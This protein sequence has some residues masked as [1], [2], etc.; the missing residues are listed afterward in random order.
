[1]ITT[2]AVLRFNEQ[3]EAYLDSVHPGIEIEDVLDNTG[4]K[5]HVADNVGQTREPN[6]EELKA[7]RE[8]DKEAFWTS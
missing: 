7:I 5:L 1:M 4:W 2:K 8:Y 6:A 3:A